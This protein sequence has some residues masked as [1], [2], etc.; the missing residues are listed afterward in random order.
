MLHITNHHLMIIND[1]KKQHA[2]WHYTTLVGMKTS[3]KYNATSLLIHFLC[4]PL[5]FIQY[6]PEPW[7]FR[8]EGGESINTHSAHL[9]ALPLALEPSRR[10]GAP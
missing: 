7:T 8:E 1:L 6:G 10:G 4:L 5:Y 9:Y 2:A 3:T